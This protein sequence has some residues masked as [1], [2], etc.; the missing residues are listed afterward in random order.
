MQSFQ[1]STE[2]LKSQ[3]EQNKAEGDV[4]LKWNGFNP[5]DGFVALG[6]DGVVSVCMNRHSEHNGERH[7][8]VTY[9]HASKNI[10]PLGYLPVHK[11]NG[12][13]GI[14]GRFGCCVHEPG[15]LCQMTPNG[16]FV[17]L[18]GPLRFAQTNSLASDEPVLLIYEVSTAKCLFEKNCKKISFLKC[19]PIGI[20]ISPSGIQ[21]G[22]YR[23]AMVTEK[24]EV[25]IWD[26]GLREG[27]VLQL[28]AVSQCLF[29]YL[30][31]R[32]PHESCIKFS[33]D[34]QL[35][36]VLCYMESE[37]TCACLILRA[38]DLELLCWMA[39]DENHT[40]LRWIFPMFSACGTKLVL[41]TYSDSDNKF[42]LKRFELLFHKVSLR[43]QALKFLCRVVILGAV[44][45]HSL[46][47]LPLPNDLIS[48]LSC[49]SA[50]QE[51]DK[52]NITVP[53]KSTTCKCN[54]M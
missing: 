52:C 25:R 49:S 32:N 45:P 27:S 7:E 5:P 51:L 42:D 54:L 1:T 15:V 26:T 41:G 21:L 33:P 13:F 47:K 30:S 18:F 11:C 40:W 23:V 22:R 10:Q 2:H 28:E 44:H 4:S 34:G 50:V 3:I 24:M 20:S 29:N 16:D 38:S 37:G 9:D 53:E 6:G 14:M 17:V 43:V 35:L 12:D 8:V 31:N 19:S 48:Y 46:E 39:A 36:S